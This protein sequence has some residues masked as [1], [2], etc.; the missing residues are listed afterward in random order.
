MLIKDTE[1]HGMGY[2]KINRTYLT[3]M[4]FKHLKVQKT[5]YY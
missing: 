4:S 5:Y 1:R 3:Y 2:A